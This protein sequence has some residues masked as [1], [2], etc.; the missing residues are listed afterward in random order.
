MGVFFGLF[1][2]SVPSIF[3]LDT[4]GAF[5]TNANG[6]WVWL[7]PVIFASSFAP[8]AIMNVYGENVL[9]DTSESQLPGHGNNNNDNNRR[10]SIGDQAFET[11]QDHNMDPQTR[12][13]N[14]WYYLFIQSVVQEI[15]ICAFIWLDC[16]PNFGSQPNF[17]E[18][19]L[20][21]KQDWRWFFGL[22]GA[23]ADVTVRAIVFVG[24]YT[25]S[26]IGTSQMLR[27]TEGATWTAV[28]AALVTP[29]GGMFWLFFELDSDTNW[30]GWKPNF[31]SS[32][33]YIIIGL[34]FMS[35][36]IYLYDKE[37]ADIE[38]RKEKFDLMKDCNPDDTYNLDAYDALV[39]NKSPPE[40]GGVGSAHAGHVQNAQTS[41]AG[42]SQEYRAVL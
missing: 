6:V 12:N 8:A 22:D 29:L 36:F 1:L 24:C 15:T 4:S 9:K 17:H 2:A 28:V 32:S 20:N 42:R 13:V 26:Y 40:N 35:P 7:W 10:L 5:K 39:V 34:L 30:F 38:A 16:V 11:V 14:I 33:I 21:I 27:F 19:M 41:D 23:N 31:N 18:S 3:G 25:L 37:A